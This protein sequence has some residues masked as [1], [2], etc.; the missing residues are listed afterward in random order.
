MDWQ[1]RNRPGKGQG[2]LCRP[3][4]LER[5]AGLVR[6]AAAAG[7]AA[8]ARRQQQWQR[9]QLECSSTSRCLDREQV[10]WLIIDI[11]NSNSIS[12]NAGVVT[13]CFLFTICM[14]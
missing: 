1:P 12:C 11:Q 8:A 14:L 3:L 7:A 5:Q 9:W 10:S 4:Q 6:S 2:A 13:L